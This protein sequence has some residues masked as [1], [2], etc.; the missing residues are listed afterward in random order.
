MRGGSGLLDG[1]RTAMRE[2]VLLRKGPATRGEPMSESSSAAPSIDCWSWETA[3]GVQGYVWHAGRP[4]GILLLQHGYREYAKRYVTQY[5][6][7]IPRLLGAGLEVYA[8]DLRGHGASSGR[9]GMM[10]IG[11]AAQDHLAARGKLEARPLP[12]F[13]MGHSLG[14]LVTAS[15]VALDQAGVSGAI[16]SS[17]ALNLASS[18]L[19]RLAARLLAR[20]APRLGVPHPSGDPAALSRL[21]EVVDAVRRDPLMYHGKMPARVAATA[22]E[23]DHVNWKRLPKWTVPTLILHGTADRATDPEG[24]RRLFATI[25]SQDK[26]LHLV[27]GGYHELLNDDDRD[28]TLQIVLKWLEERIRPR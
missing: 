2:R 4:R 11:Q 8:L 13:V 7:L 16:L 9:R 10:D 14:G 15:S 25:A 5:N 12:V 3:P 1:S 6:A 17:P 21:P 19:T 27:E 26:T 24:S 23:Q 28:E 22:I 20:I 18:A